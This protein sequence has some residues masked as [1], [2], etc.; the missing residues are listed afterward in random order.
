M[1]MKFISL[2]MS[3]AGENPMD[4]T[5]DHCL[6]VMEVVFVVMLANKA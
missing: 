6:F 5:F 2:V 4:S 3:H 1:L